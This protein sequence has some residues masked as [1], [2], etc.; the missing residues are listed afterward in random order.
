MTENKMSPSVIFLVATVLIL[1]G[2]SSSAQEDLS[3][4][5]SAQINAI[6]RAG[7]PTTLEELDRWYPHVP[8]AE[9]AATVLSD[10]FSH[11]QIPDTAKLPFFAKGPLPA[12]GEALSGETA[13]AVEDVLKQ[14]QAALELIQKGAELT[15][16]RYP[17]DLKKGSDAELPHLPKIRHAVSLLL[18]RGLTGVE[19][20]PQSAVRSLTNAFA[21]AK[22][23]EAEPLII[24]QLVRIAL[25][26]LSTSTL[27]RMLNLKERRDD[28]LSALSAS[29]SDAE[30]PTSLPRAIAGELCTGISLF[31]MSP[32]DRAK[33]LGGSR[34]TPASP[35]DPRILDGDFLFY[36]RTMENVVQTAKEPYPKRLGIA[37]SLSPQIIRSA[38]E[39]KYLVSARLLPPVGTAVEKEGEN[40]AWLRSAVAALGV[41]RFRHANGKLPDSLDSLA[42]KFLGAVPLDPFDTKPLRY[43]KLSKGYLVYSIGK[44]AKDDGG[45]EKEESSASDTNYDVT[46]TVER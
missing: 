20:S 7:Y 26:R 37:K 39:Q 46:F 1:P 31:Q 35:S 22:S 16:C 12:R 19:D 43:K 45:K 23:L 15:K 13:K 38:K 29:L 32:Q 14:N 11:L 2:I 4:K 28:Q 18:L 36:L 42:P 8:A 10:G 34:T 3:A 44:D 21:I 25:Q 40:V 33:M 9:N 27:E 30:C 24:S 17:I 41:E 6:K 5:I